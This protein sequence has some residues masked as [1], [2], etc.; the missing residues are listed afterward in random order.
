MNRHGNRRGVG[1]VLDG[2]DVFAAVLEQATSGTRAGE[3]G[4]LG[5]WK[6]GSWM[7]SHGGCCASNVTWILGSI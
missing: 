1:G 4:V 5:T 6:G 7:K 2:E 3:T